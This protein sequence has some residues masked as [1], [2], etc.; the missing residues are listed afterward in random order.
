[1][2]RIIILFYWLI[3]RNDVSLRELISFTFK[4]TLENIGKKYIASISQ[5]E[6]F[7]EVRLVDIKTPFY[8]PVKYGERGIYQV[9]SETFD[10]TDWHNY[11]SVFR[12]MPSDILLDIGAAEGLFA[13]TVVNKCKK[14]FLI[15]PNRNFVKSLKKTFTGFE[16]KIEIIETAVGDSIGKISFS[17][18]ALSGSISSAGDP[19]N[20]VSLKTIDHLVGDQVISFL[21]ADIEGFELTMLKGAKQTI[22]RNRPRIVITTYHDENDSEQIIDFILSIVPEYRFKRKG[23]FHK[24]GKPVSVHFW[25]D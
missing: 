9:V 15:E 25:I 23:I 3:R 19:S 5:Y 2:R 6:D 17:D 13:L 20:E 10:N 1:M 16:N 11:Q 7:F 18:N 22:I 24:Q 8:W 21:K 4:P 14:V 12:V